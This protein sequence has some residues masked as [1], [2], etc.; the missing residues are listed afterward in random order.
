MLSAGAADADDVST[1]RH[2]VGAD[3][4]FDYA[5]LAQVPRSRGRRTLSLSGRAEEEIDR[6][7]NLISFEESGDDMASQMEER[8]MDGPAGKECGGD[9]WRGEGSGSKHERGRGCASV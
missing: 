4:E 8:E 2:V 9:R 5:S 7:E 3:D 6:G 1:I